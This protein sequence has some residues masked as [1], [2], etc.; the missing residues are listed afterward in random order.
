MNRWRW[1]IVLILAIFAVRAYFNPGERWWAIWGILLVIGGTWL[2]RHELAKEL[3]ATAAMEEDN[4]CV[5]FYV[6][7]IGAFLAGSGWALYHH[8]GWWSPVFGIGSFL[9]T[10]CIFLFNLTGAENR[11]PEQQVT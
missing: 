10:F 8:L 1:L 9:L 2:H 3:R 7:M 5:A 4:D 11:P 6:T